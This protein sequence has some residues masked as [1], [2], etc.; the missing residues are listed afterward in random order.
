MQLVA[1]K[2]QQPAKNAAEITNG[3][4]K[5]PHVCCKSVKSK[6]TLTVVVL[7]V[8]KMETL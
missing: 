1:G 6:L 5:H 2:R 3:S 8:E 7:F 4:V